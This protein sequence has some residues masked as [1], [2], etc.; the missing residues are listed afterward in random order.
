MT[1]IAFAT[2]GH[3]RSLIDALE[4][5]NCHYIGEA[6]ASRA[7]IEARLDE[8]LLPDTSPARLVVA[9]ADDEVLGLAA[10]FLVHSIVEPQPDASCQL[11]LKELFVR[12]SARGQGV[13]KA[14][15]EWVAAYARSNNC[16]RMDWNVKSHNEKGI[17]FYRSIGADLVEDRLSYRLG[18]DAIDALAA[19]RST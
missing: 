19:Q 17:A 2:G 16:A 3:R 4:E 15:M 6:A 1:Q 9:T 7:E 5:L 11:V 13:G 10:I 8:R 14:L 12:A 18:R